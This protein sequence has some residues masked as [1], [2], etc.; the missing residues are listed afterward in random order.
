[1]FLTLFDRCDHFA[2]AS[3]NVQT[4]FSLSVP[5]S[6]SACRQSGLRIQIV[7]S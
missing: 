7:D 1:L 3:F 4:A 5:T 2:A 6:S